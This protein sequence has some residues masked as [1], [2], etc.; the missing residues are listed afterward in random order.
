MIVSTAT[1]SS[2]RTRV[3]ILLGSALII[4]LLVLPKNATVERRLGISQAEQAELILR[5]E[6]AFAFGVGQLSGS[7]A[8]ELKQLEL[9]KQK[10]IEHA[11]SLLKKA[12]KADPQ[13]VKLKSKLA[14]VLLIAGSPDDLRQYF[15]LVRQLE[16]SNS[17]DSINASRVLKYI[18]STSQQTKEIN[19][20]RLKQP[21]LSNADVEKVFDP[22]WYREAALEKYY[23]HAEQFTALSQLQMKLAKQAEKRYELMVM[24]QELLTVLAPLGIVALILAIIFWEFKYKGEPFQVTPFD[25]KALI[26]VLVFWYLCQLAIHYGLKQCDWFK[27]LFSVDVSESNA[28]KIASMT[29]LSYILANVPG[30]I[31]VY[32]FAIRPSKYALFK[33]LHLNFQL[34]SLPRLYITG[35]LA[36]CAALPLVVLAFLISLKFFGSQGS[37][38]PIIALIIKLAHSQDQLAIAVLF[39]TVAILAPICEE[40]FFRAYLFQY[41][42]QHFNF[43]ISLV[44]SSAI[45]AFLHRDLGATLP[46]FTLAMIFGTVFYRTG[47]LLPS[48]IAHGLWNGSTQAFMLIFFA[49]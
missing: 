33:S 47:S 7:K 14:L 15:E 36:C 2:L 27:A 9:A 28:L 45:F 8:D 12:E 39:F 46:L 29:C 32:L 11:L 22:G 30:L 23:D 35:F 49:N 17:P 1:D 20:L 25:S 13:S 42:K 24:V 38:N 40:I 43:L 34:S 10:M 16:S 18:A 6:Q 48:I 37:S 19:S 26:K 31:G 44:I 5:Y 3:L 41:L 21:L 4:L